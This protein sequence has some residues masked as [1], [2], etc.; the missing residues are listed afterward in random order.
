MP[1]SPYHWPVRYMDSSTSSSFSHDVNANVVSRRMLSVVNIFLIVVVGLFVCIILLAVVVCLCR[2]KVTFSFLHHN[3]I[4][5]ILC[6]DYYME[7]GRM[8]FCRLFYLEDDEYSM[9]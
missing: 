4:L 2:C 9:S 5:Y 6:R 8:L 3:S 7:G 1:Q